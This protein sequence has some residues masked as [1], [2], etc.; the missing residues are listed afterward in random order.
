MICWPVSQ[1][2]ERPFEELQIFISRG[3]ERLTVMPTRH[4]GSGRYVRWYLLQKYEPDLSNGLL[5][6]LSLMRTSKTIIHTLCTYLMT[7]TTVSG[8]SEEAEFKKARFRTKF[9]TRWLCD[10]LSHFL[11]FFGYNIS[12]PSKTCSLLRQPG[13]AWRWSALAHIRIAH[14]RTDCLPSL[15][16]NL[17]LDAFL[18]TVVVVGHFLW[19]L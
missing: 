19:C 8:A 9:P 1:S 3:R 12:S 7:V 2:S 13:H 10:A 4:E 11:T 15:I 18:Q 17:L 14:P 16:S 6:P 5:L